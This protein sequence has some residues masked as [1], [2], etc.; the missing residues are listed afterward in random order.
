MNKMKILGA[1]HCILMF[2]TACGGDPSIYREKN[3]DACVR[4]QAHAN[5]EMLRCGILNEEEYAVAE[6]TNAPDCA[7]WVSLEMV[8]ENHITDCS[9]QFARGLEYECGDEVPEFFVEDCQ[10]IESSVNDPFV[11]MPILGS[12]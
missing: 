2:A 9:E 1:A 5:D 4:Y 11:G 6:D 3:T 10:V 8:T 12:L 7:E